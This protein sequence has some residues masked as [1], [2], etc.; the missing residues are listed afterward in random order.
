MGVSGILAAGSVLATDVYGDR[1][2][3]EDIQE[4]YEQAAC[5][6][7]EITIDF[8]SAHMDDVRERDGQERRELAAAVTAVLGERKLAYLFF[9]SGMESCYVTCPACEN[10]DEEI[11]FGY[12]E[13]SERIEKAVLSSKSWDGRNLEDAEAWLPALFELLGDEEGRERLRYYFGTYV[14]PECGERMPVLE[15]MEA[16]FLGE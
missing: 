12:F 8:L 7:R 2:G 11:E 4:S 15:G 5:R 6:I 10:C 9:L 1:P 14:C 3:E 13:P 16:Y